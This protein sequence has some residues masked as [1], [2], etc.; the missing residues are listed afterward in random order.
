MMTPTSYHNSVSLRRNKDGAAIERIFLMA[1]VLVFFI[2]NNIEINV[3]V[4]IEIGKRLLSPSNGCICLDLSKKHLYWVY[5]GMDDY[6]TDYSFSCQLVHINENGVSAANPDER[7]YATIGT[8]LL[9]FW[10]CEWSLI[11]YFG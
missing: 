1:R 4:I 6:Q 11:G 9:R 3:N 10:F 5:P 7:F 2:W 8:L